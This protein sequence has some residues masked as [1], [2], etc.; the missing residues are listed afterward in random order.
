MAQCRP[1]GARHP[2]TPGGAGPRPGAERR[3]DRIWTP[4]APRRSRWSPRCATSRRRRGGSLDALAQ[5]DRLI[6]ASE[7]RGRVGSRASARDAGPRAGR[8]SLDRSRP[9]S[10]P[11]GCA[12]IGYLALAERWGLVAGAKVV[13]VPP[14]PDGD[15]GHLLLL[16]AMARLPRTDCVALLAGGVEAAGV[17][18]KELLAAVRR[19]GL[20]ERVRFGGA[21]RRP[22]GGPEPGRRGRPARDPAGSRRACRRR[23]AGDGQARSSSPTGALWPRR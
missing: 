5:V 1:P 20:G 6:V 23:G 8:T 12:A 15:R 9:S 2:R 14:L 4:R 11:S 21:R 10:T 3:R 13:L 18:G 16:Q 22:A 19:A 17:Y 7:Y